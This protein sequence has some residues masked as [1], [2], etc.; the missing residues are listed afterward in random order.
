MSGNLFV[1]KVT[2]LNGK[3][4]GTIRVI[5]EETLGHYADWL[6]VATQEIRKLNG[7]RYGS[8]LR[9][10]EWVKIPLDRTSRVA[11]EEKRFEYH[12]EIEED[13]FEAYEIENF[14]KYTVKKGDSIWSLSYDVFE[15]P[16]WLIV[17]YNPD[18]DFNTL[19]P[20]QQ[21]VVPVIAQKS[22]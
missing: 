1:Q 21:L 16:L 14:E 5:A 22:T 13:F 9:L 4:V 15:V 3:P 7:R 12:K 11:F 8:P 10:S 2:N 20:L 17:K 6:G 19:K 18:V